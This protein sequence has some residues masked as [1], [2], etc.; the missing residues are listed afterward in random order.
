MNGTMTSISSKVT[1]NFETYMEAQ[2]FQDGVKV[3]S[4][5]LGEHTTVT[6]GNILPLEDKGYTTSV[7]LDREFPENFEF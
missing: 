1:R 5:M 2:A 6:I 7:I 3:L 4:G